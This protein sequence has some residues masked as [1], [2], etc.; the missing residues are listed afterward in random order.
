MSGTLRV[1][2]SCPP[3]CSSNIHLHSTIASCVPI[4]LLQWCLYLVR[5]NISPAK[6]KTEDL[7]EL[8]RGDRGLALDSVGD[9]PIMK[10]GCF[11]FGRPFDGSP[12]STTCLKYTRLFVSPRHPSMSPYV[13]SDSKEGSRISSKPRSVAEESIFVLTPVKKCGFKVGGRCLGRWEDVCDRAGAEP[14]AERGEHGA[15]GA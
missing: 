5:Q 7:L 15:V 4:G 13:I 12:S 6:L 10:H 1:R 9:L 11:L 2:C 8:T 14:Q 3:S